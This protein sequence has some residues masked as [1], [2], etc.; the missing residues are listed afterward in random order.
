[1]R[2]DTWPCAVCRTEPEARDLEQAREAHDLFVTDHPFELALPA[3]AGDGAEHLTGDQMDEMPELFRV[4]TDGNGRLFLV[5]EDGAVIARV[6]EQ[7]PSDNRSEQESARQAL[8]RLVELAI[9]DL[10]DP[11]N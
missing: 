5:T 4:L 3:L 8:T 6:V 11:M 2:A 7:G 9:P 10:V 1:M